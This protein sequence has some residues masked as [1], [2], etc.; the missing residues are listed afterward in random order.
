MIENNCY[1]S[2]LQNLNG[3]TVYKDYNVGKLTRYQT[4]GTADL[5]ILPKNEEEFVKSI[6]EVKGI[7]PCFILGGGNNL[8][9]SDNGFR[10][11]VIHTKYLTKREIK[12]NLYIAE[13]GV[14]MQTVIEDM[15]LNSLS[16]LEFAVGIPSTVGGAVCMNAGCYGKSVG[17]LV[18]YVITENGIINKNNCQF[19]YRQSKFLVENQAVIKVCFSLNPSEIDVIEEK[20]KGYKNSR[21]NPKGRSCG[22]V[23]KNDGCFAGKVI[24]ECGLKGLT[25]GG[26]FVSKEHAN[27]IIASDNCTSQNIYDLILEVK[28]KVYDKTKIKLNEELVYLGDF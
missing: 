11:A 22:S 27:F 10:G 13:C 26:A 20:I 9:V 1:K 19:T 15:R 24:D 23:F 5:Y 18:C 28:N 12:G 25:V 16:G 3:I 2:I 21:R 6:Q 8:L 14:K 4:G 7:C 17:E